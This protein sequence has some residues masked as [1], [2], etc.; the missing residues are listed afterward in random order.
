MGWTCSET[1]TRIIMALTYYSGCLT[2]LVVGQNSDLASTSCISFVLF[3]FRPH[4]CLLV[5]GHPL[6]EDM[7]MTDGFQPRI[8]TCRLQVPV[9]RLKPALPF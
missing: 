1:K 3:P 2:K 6:V 5:N 7:P 8:S 9:V 4:H